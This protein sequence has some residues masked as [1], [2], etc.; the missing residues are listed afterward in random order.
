M[1]A[2][3]TPELTARAHGLRRTGAP[4]RSRRRAACAVA[5]TVVSLTFLG[6]CFTF[7]AGKVGP[8]LANNWDEPVTITIDSTDQVL[9]ARAN[10]VESLGWTDCAGDGFTLTLD[11]GTV[12]GHYDGALC[13]ETAIAMFEDG[14][15]VVE[16]GGSNEEREPTDP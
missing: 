14:T 16:D 4:G 9:I 11:D 5:L 15:F 12:L 3:S 6:G 2:R 13:P 10:F 1:S 8:R 7:D